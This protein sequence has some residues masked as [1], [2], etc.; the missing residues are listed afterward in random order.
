MMD[1]G[2]QM[3]KKGAKVMKKAGLSPKKIA[4]FWNE[5]GTTANSF[6]HQQLAGQAL[7]LLIISALIYEDLITINMPNKTEAHF[8]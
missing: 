3:T 1:H 8:S 7:I 6:T 5:Q 2:R 4:K